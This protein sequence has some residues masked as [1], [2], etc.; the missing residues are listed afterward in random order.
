MT[1]RRF[2]PG[3]RVIM[4]RPGSFASHIPNLQDA[5]AVIQKQIDGTVWFKFVDPKAA[6]AWKREY[7]QDTANNCYAHRFDLLSVDI[8]IDTVR[9]TRSGLAVSNVA[10]DGDLIRADVAV[11]GRTMTLR[12]DLSGSFYPGHECPIDLI[13]ETA[14]V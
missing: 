9:T 4:K 12:Y 1:E 8:R 10:R 14:N 2:K 13:G 3:D 6:A 5:I 11:D 7:P